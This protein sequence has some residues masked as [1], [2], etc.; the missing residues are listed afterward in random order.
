MSEVIAGCQI[1]SVQTVSLGFKILSKFEHRN[2]EKNV[3]RI[4]SSID[5]S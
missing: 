5:T 4:P 2:K 1:Y 3:E